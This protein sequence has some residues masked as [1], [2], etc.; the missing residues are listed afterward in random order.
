MAKILDD[1]K[2]L[3]DVTPEGIEDKSQQA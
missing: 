2:N 3:I 1:H